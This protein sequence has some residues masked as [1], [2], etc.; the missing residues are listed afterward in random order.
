MK[1]LSI[2][3]PYAELILQGRKTIEAR[4]KIS[5]FRGEFLVHTSKTPDKEAMKR[6]GFEELPCGFIIGK[7]S[8]VGV[9]EYT[10]EKEFRQDKN[11]HLSDFGLIRYGWILKNPKRINSIP[12]RG[13]LG[14]WNYEID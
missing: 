4:T 9:K 13:T 11:L 7:V 2:K 5:H 1:V 14:F 10:N 12:A 6:F 8:L 3:Q